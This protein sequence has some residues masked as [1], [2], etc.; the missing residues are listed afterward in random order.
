LSS[1]SG[2]AGTSARFERLRRLRP[3]P[4]ELFTYAT[5]LATLFFLRSQGLAYGWN[6]VVYY[7]NG[8][9]L[10]VVQ[11]TLLGI[12]LQTIAH[13]VVERRVRPY[14]REVATWRWIALTVRLWFVMLAFAYTYTWLKVSIPLV[15]T[16]LFDVELWH[17]DRWLHFGVSPTVLAIE[18]VAG[19]PL[20]HWV[21]RFYGW[22]LPSIPWIMCY[23][24]TSAG[25]AR[26]RNFVFANAIMWITGAWLY[27]SL[28]ALGP[29]FSSPDVLEPIRQ[30]MPTAIRSQEILWQNYL[31]LVRSRGTMLE[32][33]SPLYGVA[34]IPS[35]HVA[36]YAMYTLWARRY[37]RRWYPLGV[38]ATAFIFFGSL[39]TGWHYAVDGYLGLLL[40]WVSVAVADRFEPVARPP[41]PEPEPAADAATPAE[42][43]AG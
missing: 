16:R 22:W 7:F 13:A 40:A 30:A 21:D 4:F 36:A 20:A 23:L 38:A 14:L 17:L 39:A 12:G 9:A 6:T 24:F 11:V 8:F 41:E 28:P 19:T 2:E 15:R 42:E 31:L 35:L 43:G 27:I 10:R 18:L 34:A 26:R 5:T 25:S 29:C 1:N 37:A 32:S 3:A 33:F